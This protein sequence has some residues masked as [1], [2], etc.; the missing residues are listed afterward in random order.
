MNIDDYGIEI[1]RAQTGDGMAWKLVDARHLPPDENRGK[2]NAYVTILDE[3]GNRLHD[4]RLKICWDWQGRRED[5]D[6]PP[7][8]L[9]KPYPE[10]SGNVDLYPKMRASLRICGDGNDSDVVKNV[11]TMHPGE[12]GSGGELFN[13][14]GHHSFEFIFQR[15]YNSITPDEPEPPDEDIN[16]EGDVALTFP[17]GTT[18]FGT[19]VGKWRERND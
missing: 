11:H 12:A 7:M 2:H 18:K 17:D 8:P 16:I 1:D 6:N 3:Y 15:V 4:P 14:Y 9:D 5:E 10:P 13:S 19:I